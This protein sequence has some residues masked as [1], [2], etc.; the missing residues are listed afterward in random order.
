[1]GLSYKPLSIDEPVFMFGYSY[2]LFL[3][4]LNG[5]WRLWETSWFEYGDSARII[6][7]VDIGNGWRKLTVEFNIS[8]YTLGRIGN[9]G[10]ITAY[11]PNA[12]NG[13][14]PQYVDDFFLELVSVSTS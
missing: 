3:R 5:T 14:G 8:A 10:S 12:V 11:L 7:D 2:F 6:S 9:K 4:N 13:Y 1:M